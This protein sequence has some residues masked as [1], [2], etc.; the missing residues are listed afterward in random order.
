L[1]L[2]L[3][4]LALLVIEVFTLRSPNFLWPSDL[5]LLVTFN[6]LLMRASLVLWA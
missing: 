3:A 6:E 4:G 2:A 1:H 5:I